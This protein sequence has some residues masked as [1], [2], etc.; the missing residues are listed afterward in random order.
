[1]PTALW[2]EVDT[3]STSWT[4]VTFPS[5]FTAFTVQ[6]SGPGDVFVYTNPPTGFSSDLYHLQIQ[7]GDSSPHIFYGSTFTT[8]ALKVFSYSVSDYGTGSYSF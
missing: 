8:I 3:L 7:A 1:M 2:Q 6:N 4:T 5:T